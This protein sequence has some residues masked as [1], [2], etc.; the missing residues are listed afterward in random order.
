[1]SYE[2]HPKARHA[3]IDI[4]VASST[5]LPALIGAIFGHLGHSFARQIPILV[6]IHLA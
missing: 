6:S 1:M 5:S 4:A 2:A 3:A